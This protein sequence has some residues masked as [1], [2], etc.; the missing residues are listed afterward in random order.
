TGYIDIR[1]QPA[2]NSEKIEV[3]IPIS[4]MESAAAIENDNLRS[5]FL[6]TAQKAYQR[7][8]DLRQKGWKPCSCGILTEDG[9]L[10]YVCR[11]REEEEKRDVI[12]FFI[13]RYPNRS[14]E[15]AAALIPDLTH[16][17]WERA[18]RDLRDKIENQLRSSALSI[19]KNRRKDL[20]PLIEP[21]KRFLLLG[22]EEKD[23]G[24]II[25]I[26]LWNELQKLFIKNNP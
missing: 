22:G 4:I 23:L 5:A 16:H 14:W 10:C 7:E 18:R 17:D 15:E 20:N 3:D 19:R 13:S 6:R 8:Y 9:S 25:G 2:K 12:L 1:E 26:D 21:A 11:Q 24:H